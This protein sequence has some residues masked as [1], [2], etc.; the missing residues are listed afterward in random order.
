[1]DRY[2][3]LRV[4][5]KES[6]RKKG[7]VPYYGANGIQD[8]VEGYTHNGEYILIAEDGANDLSEY[9]VQYVTGKIWVNNHA[10]VGA[11]K[12]GLA[13]TLFLKYAISKADIKSVLVG[14]T[15]AKLTSTAL[16][17]LSIAIPPTCEE[18]QRIAY[19]MHIL[20][21]NITNQSQQVEKLKQLKKACLSQMFE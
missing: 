9:P 6:E 13:S 18:Q 11:A 4:P 7:L 21:S 17:N 8:Y 12:S 15:R 1:M 3:S 5:I 10:H 20:E 14:G 2:D 16:M 19:F